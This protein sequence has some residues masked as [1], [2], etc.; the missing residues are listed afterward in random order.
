MEMSAK[1][2]HL[3]TLEKIQHMLDGFDMS[4]KLSNKLFRLAIVSEIIDATCLFEQLYKSWN[5][6]LPF[7]EGP[8]AD[9]DFG[10]WQNI[11]TWNELRTNAQQNLCIVPTG[12]D[13]GNGT[14]SDDSDWAKCRKT[15]PKF[16][17][18]AVKSSCLAD[19]KVL[20]EFAKA[21]E[22]KDFDITS[23]GNLVFYSLT[24]LTSV[25][26]KIQML[27][28]NPPER[29]MNEYCDNQRERFTEGFAN[30]RKKMA[31]ILKEDLPERRKLNKLKS[32]RK[33]LQSKLFDSS[34]VDNLISGVTEFDVEDYRQEHPETDLDDTNIKRVIALDELV[35]T[36]GSLMA[37]AGK[38]IYENRKHL[39]S[40]AIG[41]FF[42]YADLKPAL[43]CT[44][45]TFG[46]GNEGEKLPVVVADKLQQLTKALQNTPSNVSVAFNFIGG[47]L[48]AHKD[49]N[50]DKNF[51]AI[52]TTE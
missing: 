34:F 7:G 31:D 32:F 15:Y 10:Y 51:G 42:V 2:L 1:S 16:L 6:R 43:D 27:L 26:R 33:E 19:K 38:Y 30:G 46:A 23:F 3:E 47:D 37:K 28:D 45:A 29:L 8:D 5:E 50:I 40:Q 35:K 12:I 48:V 24:S 39:S 25:L 21:L 17:K 18:A 22:S 13:L 44:I 49:A 36:D 11:D 20:V 14:Y 4:F 52:L 9:V 41:D